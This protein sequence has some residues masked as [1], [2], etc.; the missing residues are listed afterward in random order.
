MSDYGSAKVLL[1]GLDGA[2]WRI[3]EPLFAEGRLPN[4]KSI[5]E[6]GGRSVLQSTMPPLTPPAW[7]SLMTGMNPGKHGVLT[8]RALDYSRYSSY[9]ERLATS[10][11]FSHLSV[12]RRLSEAGFRVASVGMPMTYPPFEVNGFMI[13][14]TP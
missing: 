13:S 6:R 2:S 4:L 8:F 10:S 11:T 14:G 12:F 1:V 7:A 5:V 9:V 3:I